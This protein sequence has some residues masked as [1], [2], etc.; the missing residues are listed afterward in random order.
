M[1]AALSTTDLVALADSPANRL[2]HSFSLPFEQLD[3]STSTGST[4][5]ATGIG[6]QTA[7]ALCSLGWEG[8][9]TRTSKIGGD[10]NLA[11]LFKAGDE[12]RIAVKSSLSNS[13]DSF[14]FLTGGLA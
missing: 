3:N 9:S 2:A 14:I 10:D 8:L 7:Y 5:K 13:Q 1:L 12:L 4:R 11:A 6:S